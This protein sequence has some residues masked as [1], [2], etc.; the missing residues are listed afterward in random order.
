[1]PCLSFKERRFDNW[2]DA[3]MWSGNNG[4]TKEA[5]K[6]VVLAPSAPHVFLVRLHGLKW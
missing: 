6:E 3:K 1:M 5:Q 2:L 4:S